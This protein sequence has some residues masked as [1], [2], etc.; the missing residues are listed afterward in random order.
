MVKLINKKKFP[1]KGTFFV[2]YNLFIL[3]F[4]KMLVFGMLFFI[5]FSILSP[6]R[7]KKTIYLD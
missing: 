5:K 4:I 7:I 2:Y 1:F 6:D 3:C